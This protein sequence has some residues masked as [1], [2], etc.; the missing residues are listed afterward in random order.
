MYKHV[1]WTSSFTSVEWEVMAPPLQDIQ[2]HCSMSTGVILNHSTS[3]EFY[4]ELSWFHMGVCWLKIGKNCAIEVCTGQ[5]KNTFILSVSW[6][7]LG[8]DFPYLTK[9]GLC[10]FDWISAF[11]KLEALTNQS[12]RLN[13]PSNYTDYCNP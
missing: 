1:L 5:V 2:Y 4:R 3:V 11:L 6:Q 13:F 7:K 8:K 9:N 12:E 10:V